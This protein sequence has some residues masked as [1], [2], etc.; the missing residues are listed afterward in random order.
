MRRYHPSLDTIPMPTRLAALPVDAR[1][2]PVPWFVA[3]VGG[4]PDHRIV[5]PEKVR[6][7]YR[8]QRCFLCGERRGRFLSFVIGP[9]CTV[10]RLSA[11]PPS[12]LDCARYAVQACPFLARPHMVRRDAGLPDQVRDA[13]GQMLRHN[14]GVQA[15]WTTRDMRLVRAGGGVLCRL[16]D[17]TAVEWYAEGR[18]ATRAEVEAAFA[19]GMPVLDEQARAEG[20]QAA[21][22]LAQLAQAAQRWLPPR[23]PGGTHG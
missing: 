20:P 12:H 5:D 22:L 7:A 18:P 15:V 21:L 17:P 10:N 2:F 1:G 19:R 13:P 4:Q 23:A 6:R 8:D 14:P 9:M 16:G 11:E 3:W